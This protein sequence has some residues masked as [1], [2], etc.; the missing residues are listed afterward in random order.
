MSAGTNR[1][2]SGQKEKWWENVA[3]IKEDRR[4]WEKGRKYTYIYIIYIHIYIEL[5]QKP[6]PPAEF[7]RYFQVTSF[8]VPLLRGWSWG[9]RSRL[10][11]SSLQHSMTKVVFRESLVMQKMSGSG[12]DDDSCLFTHLQAEFAPFSEYK[13]TKGG[14]ERE[15]E[16]EKRKQRKRETN[17]RVTSLGGGISSCFLDRA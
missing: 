6:E 16:R 7:F 17:Q 13:K 4:M 2:I 15:R 5:Q 8:T 14:R 11:K 3:A 9:F 12:C 1:K 10:Q